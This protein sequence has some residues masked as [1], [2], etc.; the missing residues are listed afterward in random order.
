[1]SEWQSEGPKPSP[2]P[3][4]GVLLCFCPTRADYVQVCAAARPFWLWKRKMGSCHVSQRLRRSCSPNF[5]VSFIGVVTRGDSIKMHRVVLN[6]LFWCR[7]V[8]SIYTMRLSRPTTEEN[9]EYAD[10]WSP[11]AL[12]CSFWVHSD[13]IRERVGV[14]RRD[15]G[16]VIFVAINDINDLVRGFLE[17]LGHGTADFD[18]V[19]GYGVSK[20]VDTRAVQTNQPQSWVGR[21]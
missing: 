6:L 13:V 18:D 16:N 21:A 19:Y 9:S 15:W 1:M 8:V 4:L 11:V 3:Y 2:C 14:R 20:D 10:T 5:S 7:L 17:R 12:S